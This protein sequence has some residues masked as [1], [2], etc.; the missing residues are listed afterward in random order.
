M[1]WKGRTFIKGDDDRN[2][3]IQLQ[4]KLPDDATWT[5]VTGSYYDTDNS[6]LDN[7]GRGQGANLNADTDIPVAI[8]PTTVENKSLVYVRWVYY[9]ISGINGSRPMM[10]VD[11]IVISRGAAA[12][13]MSITPDNSFNDKVRLPNVSAVN[14]DATDPLLTTGIKLLLKN[15]NTNILASDNSYT[16]SVSSS[17][18][19]VMPVANID[20]SRGDGF[21]VLKFTPTTTAG[22]S[23]IKVTLSNGSTSVSYTINYA[24][25]VSSNSSTLWPTS[26][27][28][29]STMQMLSCND[30]LIA[31]DET[32]VVYIYNK[33]GSGLPI[34]TF[35]YNQGNALALTDGNPYKEVDVEASV[36][37]PN[38]AGKIYFLG[39][40][41]NSS[42]FNNK[43]NRDRVFALNV[44]GTAAPYTIANA[45]YKSGLRAALVSWGDS[46]GYN[47]SASAADG[48]D[49]KAIDGFNL[50]GMVF[51]PNN[52]TLYVAFRAPLVP[53]SNR[54]KAV[55][56]PILNFESYFS[57]TGSPSIGQ[58]IELNLGGRG[59]R[60][61]FR[62]VNGTY[63]IIAGRPDDGAANSAVY[64]WSGIATE[65]PILINDFGLSTRNVEGVID[66]SEYCGGVNNNTLTFI[67]DNGTSVYYN[68]AVEAK[69]LATPEY[70]KFMMFTIAGNLNVL[71]VNFLSFTA[72]KQ[73]K[74][75]VLNWSIN[76]ALQVSSFSIFGSND[77]GNFI[78]IAK[79]P[80]VNGKSDYEFKEHNIHSSERFY[81]I[82][83]NDLDG[84]ASKS[85]VRKLL[86]DENEELTIYPNPA[87]NNVS[88][89]DM[90]KS[91]SSGTITNSLGQVVLNFKYL[92][93]QILNV[94]QFPAGVYKVSLYQGKKHVATRTLTKL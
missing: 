32:N 31:D 43:P 25:S 5:N 81:Y 56:A 27:A 88:I 1:Q 41:S 50:E 68:D 82:R 80:F 93:G 39:S 60:D 48:K 10:G 24:G 40:M 3:R 4:Y 61:I 62:M 83:E 30:V 75:A 18:T 15:N 42:S 26:I 35:D 64:R 38:T 90:G 37:S 45:G 23:T 36:K 91:Y 17:N 66:P 58:P 7:S 2:F 74:D 52:T 76:G 6:I 70:K 29:A 67:A 51:A 54:T 20:V 65:Q 12:S 77:G 59:I 19:S 71:P 14:N 28:D 86:F 46:K 47:F 94:S 8:L 72:R 57:G 49:P 33:D 11:Q 44:T 73:G 85:P 89:S 21:A 92:P 69:V 55:I 78:E 63:V 13:N 53:T 16:I 9:M 84:G 22:Y 79:V 87:H 34:Q